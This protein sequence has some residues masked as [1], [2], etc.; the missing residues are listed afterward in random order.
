MT[1]SRKLIGTAAA[2]T[3]AAVVGS[4]G[5]DPRS[6]WYRTLSKPKWQPPGQVFGPV[7]TVLYALI[8]LAAARTLQ[9]TDDDAARTRYTIAFGVNLLLNVAWSWL[10]FSAKRPRLA[11]AEILALELSTI[12]LALRSAR[13]DKT[14][15][16]LLFPYAG[17]VAFAAALN[18]A[19]VHR[20]PGA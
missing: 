18:A 12:D 3:A 9:R 19:I 13:R 11:L 6:V 5:T 8:A 20:N 17:W 7:W 2:V 1:G 16:A 15:G 4:I 14:A 10:F